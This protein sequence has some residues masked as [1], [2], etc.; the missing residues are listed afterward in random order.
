MFHNSE[1]FLYNL[2]KVFRKAAPKHLAL[3]FAISVGLW[4]EPGRHP[5]PERKLQTSRGVS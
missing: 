4:L 3:P 1:Q 2:T 5:S